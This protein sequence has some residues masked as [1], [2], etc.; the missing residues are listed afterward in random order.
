MKL[1]DWHSLSPSRSF[2][3]FTLALDLVY[4]SSTFNFCSLN[5]AVYLSSRKRTSVSSS[6]ILSFSWQDPFRSQ[7]LW[8]NH[9]SFAWTAACWH[10]SHHTSFYLCPAVQLVTK[11][12]TLCAPLSPSW[13]DHKL[14]TSAT[15]P[16]QH[17]WESTGE[18]LLR[19]VSWLTCYTVCFSSLLAGMISI[20]I[21]VQC[22]SSSFYQPLPS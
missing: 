12:Y 16:P 17:S 21:N 14:K 8:S 9:G 15:L 1:L 19:L 11:H 7:H 20:Q 10:Q 6:A 3:N 13:T 5:F 2:N 22:G 4:C 18:N